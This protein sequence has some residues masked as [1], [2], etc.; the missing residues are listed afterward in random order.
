MR[1]W[2]AVMLVSILPC[3]HLASPGATAQAFELL[4]TGGIYCRQLAG[5]MRV[6]CPTHT[7]AC[8]Y[9]TSIGLFYILHSEGWQQAGGTRRGHTRRSALRH[10][11]TSSSAAISADWP[12][13][14]CLPPLRFSDARGARRRNCQIRA[15][16]AGH[17]RE[18]V[19]AEGR[20]REPERRDMQQAVS[21]SRTLTA[22]QRRLL[23]RLCYV[24]ACAEKSWA[25]GGRGSTPGRQKTGVHAGTGHG[26][27]RCISPGVCP[28]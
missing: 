15:W 11:W 9:H 18:C 2:P 21:P 1:S 25:E 7:C 20:M 4:T 6:N 10:P 24:A 8:T 16:K 27:L 23:T 22:D 17:K 19:L 12:Q 26:N 13:A 3:R 5:A 14:R 28:R